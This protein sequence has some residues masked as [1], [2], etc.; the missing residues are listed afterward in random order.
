[1]QKYFR[2]EDW[3]FRVGGDEFVVIAENTTPEKSAGIT[4][5]IV[6]INE[7]LSNEE[8]SCPAVSVTAG[9]AFGYDGVDPDELFKKADLALYRAKKSGKHGCAVYD[10]KEESNG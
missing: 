4:D 2:A 6:C 8:G 5:K 10:D 1:M 3:M 7:E 9:I